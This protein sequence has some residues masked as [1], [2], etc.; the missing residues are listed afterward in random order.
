MRSFC[1][2]PQGK[3]LKYNL[4]EKRKHKL[5]QQSSNATAFMSINASYDEYEQMLSKEIL[6]Q[7]IWRELVPKNP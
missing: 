1:S 5:N 7:I 3:S 2:E 6:I 4:K